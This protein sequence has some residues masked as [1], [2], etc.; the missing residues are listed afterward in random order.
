METKEILKKLRND[1][2]LTLV[3]LSK[4]VGIAQSTLSRY[5]SGIRKPTKIEQIQKLA[6]F[7]NVDSSFILGKTEDPQALDLWEDATGHSPEVIETKLA[8]LQK[9]G[10]LGPNKQKNISLAVASLEGLASGHGNRS[11]IRAATNL[12]TF[13][14][15][16]SNYFIDP[17]KEPKA[18][19]EKLRRKENNFGEDWYYDDMDPRL[20]KLISS[21]FTAARRIIELGQTAINIKDN[22]DTLST[23]D[24]ALSELRQ[25]IIELTKK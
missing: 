3:Q 20:M 18:L 16:E 11:A 19:M 1:K 17:K 25:N 2:G 12:L 13:S 22:A 9:L 14:N 4:E 5:E 24:D 7:Y 10:L 8:E 15:I 21:T 6:D 23:I